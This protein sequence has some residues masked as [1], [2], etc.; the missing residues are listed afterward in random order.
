MRI[1]DPRVL[2]GAQI[3][4]GG[5]FTPTQ[6][7]NLTMWLKAD[8]ITGLSDGE[9]V[10]TWPDSG[11]LGNGAT[12]ATADNQP[13]YKANIINGKPVI[14]FDGTNDYLVTASF[15]GTG[16]NTAFTCYAIAPSSAANS[17]RIF[18]SNQLAKFFISGITIDAGL[19]SVNTQ[20]DFKATN[21]SPNT[22]HYFYLPFANWQENAAY[23]RN[24]KQVIGISYDGAN[25]TLMLNGV[26]KQWATTGD[27]GLSG[28]FTI[29]AR[30]TP[31]LYWG[32]AN[33]E[34]TATADIAEI[35]IYNAA[36][37]AAQMSQVEQYLSTKYNIPI[38][39]RNYTL[40]G[41]SHTAGSF[42]ESGRGYPGKLLDITPNSQDIIIY[43]NARQ[44]RTLTTMMTL[45]A[46]YITS[47]LAN[48]SKNI[49][50]VWGGVN[51][52]ATPG[53][54]AAELWTRLSHV[55]TAMVA[56]G[57]QTIV[58]TEIDAQD[59]SRE[60]VGWHSTIWP[61]FNTLIRENY[62]G[63]C[64][65]IADLAGNAVFQNALDTTYYAADKIHIKD[66]ANA[67]AATII[68]AAIDA[69]P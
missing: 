28:A 1:L 44:G 65:G 69:L 48:Y 34:E 6:L 50:I 11:S 27:M 42:S 3:V 26:T 58:C 32:A 19:N 41:D 52:A 12:Q 9:A 10:T 46:G 68:K 66:A 62:A 21:L 59:A 4:T 15:L 13:V 2:V 29:G 60:A 14:R 35:I 18:I 22:D 63:V 5:G 33:A 47:Y 23:W 54:D 57:Y 61:A 45:E 20:M 30:S 8:A 53:T 7:P 40:V 38:K 16:Y 49:A 43:N 31:D 55:C 39:T 64:D 25:L 17:Q 37:T 56:G 24:P 36:H 67:V 51:D